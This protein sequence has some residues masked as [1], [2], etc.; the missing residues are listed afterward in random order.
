MQTENL[1]TTTKTVN[2]LDI[3]YTLEANYNGFLGMANF[4]DQWE[5]SDCHIGGVTIQGDDGQNWIPKQYSIAQLSKDYA[6]QG[7]DNPSGK[8]YQSLREQFDRDSQA[9][10]VNVVVSVCMNGVELFEETI[11]GSDYEHLDFNY[12]HDKALET[13]LLDYCEED[14]YIEQALETIKQLVA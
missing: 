11:I 2:G 9:F 8:A 14:V 10:E 4:Q 1:A 6:K 7:L 3:T 12:D 5:N 13:F